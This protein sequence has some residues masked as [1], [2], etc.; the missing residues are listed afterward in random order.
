MYRLMMVVLAVLFTASTALAGGW[1]CGGGMGG[2]SGCGG[3]SYSYMGGCGGYSRMGSVY[4]GSV[5]GCGGYEMFDECGTSD[6]YALQARTVTSLNGCGCEL[7]ANYYENQLQASPMPEPQKTTQPNPSPAP[8]TNKPDAPSGPGPFESTSYRPQKVSMVSA[9]VAKTA[10][11]KFILELPASAKVWVN[12]QLT[13]S[14]GSRREYLSRDLLVGREYKYR[15]VIQVG[16]QV[17][18]RDIVLTAGQTK[19]IR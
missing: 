12:D 7:P 14:Q 6:G 11:A 13:R 10:D 4:Y 1:G 19:T 15:V 16:D 18:R 17:V 2:W 9:T 8:A 3:G 5:G